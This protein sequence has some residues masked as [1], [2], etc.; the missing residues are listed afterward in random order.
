MYIWWGANLTCLYND[1][2]SLSIGP[3]RHPVSL[4][5]RGREVWDEIWD[6]IGPQ[7]DQVMSGRGATW[8]E[9][10]LIPITRHGQREDV[11]WTYSY[12]PI[13][14]QTARHGVGGVLVVCSET[15]ATV[16]AEKRRKAEHERQRRLFERAPSFMCIL[17][18]PAHIFEFVNDAH[19]QLFNSHDWTGKPVREAFTDL[20]GQGFYELLDQVRSSGW[21]SKRSRCIFA[22]PPLKPLRRV[23]S[24]SFTNPSSRL[25]E[26]SAAFSAK[27]SMSPSSIR[28]KK[29]CG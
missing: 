13:R 6:I 27:A 14:D 2:Y 4:G 25:M 22:P 9:N 11:Y 21:C 10:A 20:A 3:E 23:C 19:R 24:I 16:L 28:P 26:R 7:I 8:N 5:K 29:H 18:G 1:A 17:T 12:S 15:T